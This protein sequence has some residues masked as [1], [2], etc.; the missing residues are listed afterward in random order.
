MYIQKCL[1]CALLRIW[2]GTFSYYYLLLVF[3]LNIIREDFLWCVLSCGKCAGCTL[4]SYCILTTALTF[5][6]SHYFHYYILY[7]AEFLARIKLILI[8]Y[9]MIEYFMDGRVCIR[10]WFISARK[11]TINII[12]F[13]KCN[14]N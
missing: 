14:V 2:S 12:R 4:N 3:E 5:R 1:W 6:T 9:I 13:I 8:F 10:F 11:L 7:N